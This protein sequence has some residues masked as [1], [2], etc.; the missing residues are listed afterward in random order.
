MVMATLIVNGNLGI[1]NGMDDDFISDG[2]IL[3]GPFGTILGNNASM[4]LNGN[5]AGE[6]IYISMPC[7]F[8]GDS[9]QSVQFNNAFFRSIYMQS[10][11]T[12]NFIG[13]LK[14]DSIIC[15][16]NCARISDFKLVPVKR[17]RSIFFLLRYASVR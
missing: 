11:S 15:S 16:S 6:N 12:V 10:D 2:N 17:S 8:R 14:A 9:I 13:F 1:A 5:M 3:M 4:Q 7:F